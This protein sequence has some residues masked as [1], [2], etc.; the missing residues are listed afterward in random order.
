MLEFCTAVKWSSMMKSTVL[1]IC[2]AAAAGRL[3]TTESKS[4]EQ[5]KD[6]TPSKPDAADK[7]IGKEAGQIRD[8]NGLKIKLVWCPPG[9]FKMGTPR[10]E[11]NRFW[12]EGQVD[13]ALPNGFWLGKYEVTQ[14]EWKQLMSTEP[15]K[16]DGNMKVGDAFPATYV[17]WADAV[18]FCC[19]LTE[20][21]RK[22]G[23]LSEGWE[24]T[25]PTEAQWEYA[26]RA[27]TKTNFSFG[28][29]ESKLGE[30]AWFGDRE[31]NVKQYAHPVGEKKSNPWGLHDMHGNVWEWCRDTYAI[32]VPTGALNPARVIR[33]GSWYSG[34]SHCDSA[35]RGRELPDARNVYDGFRLAATACLPAEKS[36]P[37]EPE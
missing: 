33:G 6:A 34:W 21:E 31:K 24:Y 8:D 26:C 12:E 19:K 22:A 35:S 9:K 18:E 36:K 29:D 23:R 3:A 16:G 30:Y 2:L 10:T 20:Q 7:F 14:S 5:G 17:S 32:K 13:V 25:L 1:L 28:D 27:E 15:W 4:D 37:G 11:R